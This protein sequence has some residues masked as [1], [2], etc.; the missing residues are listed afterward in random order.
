MSQRVDNCLVQKF[1]GYT[2]L[3]EIDLLNEL[4]SRRATVEQR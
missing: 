3:T 4:Q 1:L 2:E